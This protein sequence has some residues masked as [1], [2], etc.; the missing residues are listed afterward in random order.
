VYLDIDQSK[1]A[2]INRGFETAFESRIKEIS[3]TFEEEYEQQD[4]DACAAKVRRLLSSYEP[5]ALGL[6]CF[7]RSTGS[8]WFRELN[9][10]VETEVRWGQTAH[11]QQFVEAL[12]EFETYAVAVVDRSHGRVFTVKLGEIELRAEIHAMH[13]VGHIKTTGADHLYSQSHFQRKADEH[14]LS[15][16][17]RV[18]EVLEDLN[19]FHP[20]ER[21]VLIGSTEATSALFRLLHKSMRGRAIASGV[22]SANASESQILQEVLFLARKA[23]RSQELAKAQ[24]LIT[25]AAKDQKAVAALA[26]TIQALNGKR[27]RELVYSAGF[28]ATGGRCEPCEA[29][30]VSDMA[31]CEFCGLPVKPI[32]DLVEAAIDSALAKGAGV[33]QLRG[34]AAEKLRSAGGIGAFLRF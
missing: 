14:T 7:V 30:F 19:R 16:L 26:D 13:G 17:K 34:E 32:D 25:A 33:E 8:I 6:V 21:V 10:P 15:Q 1:A 28:T 12:D 23:E 9:V 3:R 4:F 22:L 24:R 20:F 5:R 18:A 11:V 29:I 31:N 27:V 2:N